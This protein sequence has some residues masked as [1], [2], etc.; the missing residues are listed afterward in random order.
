MATRAK[1]AAAVSGVSL[2]QA[3]DRAVKML[4]SARKQVD[5]YLPD[6]PRGLSDLQANVERVTRDLDKARSR[7]L[8]R[9]R[10]RFDAFLGDIERAA[11]DAMKPI[12]GRLDLATKSDV[13]R[14]RRRITQLEK[15]ATKREPLS[16]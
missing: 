10:H 13:D 1:R 5:R 6:R 7:V 12:V 14:L 15:R 4:R 16:A 11:T 3:Q 8:Q 9:A 2:R